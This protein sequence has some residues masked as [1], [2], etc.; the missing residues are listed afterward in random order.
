MGFTLD[1][2]S[3]D[4]KCNAQGR[5]VLIPV[6]LLDTVLQQHIH[7]S[8][9]YGTDAKLQWIWKHNGTSPTKDHLAS[10]SELYDLC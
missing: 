6:T 5:I 4:W 9:H 2:N 8:T 10:H 3:P 1:H 7:D